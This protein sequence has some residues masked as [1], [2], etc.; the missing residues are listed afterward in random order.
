MDVLF[1]QLLR[2]QSLL[3]GEFFYNNAHAWQVTKKQLPRGRGVVDVAERFVDSL[4]QLSREDFA[5]ARVLSKEL[6][7]VVDLVFIDDH[8]LFVLLP[9]IEDGLF[10][11]KLCR[12]QYSFNKNKYI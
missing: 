8:F 10:S 11:F 5:A 4:A 6:L 12:H 9:E 2:V 7:D 1:F 3:F